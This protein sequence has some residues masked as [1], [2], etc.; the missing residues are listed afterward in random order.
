MLRIEPSPII[1]LFNYSQ[2]N[3]LPSI[4]WQGGRYMARRGHPLTV[5]LEQYNKGHP[6]Q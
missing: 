2:P 6:E 5:R 1:L 3:N 4:H